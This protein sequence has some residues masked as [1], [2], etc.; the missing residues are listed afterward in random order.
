MANVARGISKSRSIRQIEKEINKLKRQKEKLLFSKK[1]DIINLTLEESLQRKRRESQSKLVEL[2]K[3]QKKYF[4]EQNRK[5]KKQLREDVDRIEWELIKVTLKEQGNN[6]AMEK[7]EKFKKSNAKPFFLW[8]L[9]FAEVFQR[10]NP[11]FDVVIA[12][13]PYVDSENMVKEMP[14]LRISYTELFISAKGNWDLFIIFIEQGLNLLRKKGDISYIVPNKLIGAKYSETLRKILVKKKVTEIRDYSGVNVFKEADVYPITFVISNKEP[15]GTVLMT[16]MNSINEKEN[17]NIIPGDLFYAD[18]DWGRYFVGDKRFLDILLKMNEKQELSKYFPNV[19]G[20]ATVNQAYKLKKILKDTNQ[21]SS[22]IKKFINTGTIDPYISL[23]GQKKTRYIKEGYMY[24]IVLESELE[25]FSD[26]RYNQACSE[27]IIIGGM[28]KNLECYYDSSEYLAGKSTTIILSGESNL[29]YLTALLNSKL[30]SFWY[31]IFFKSL[32]LSGGYLRISNNEIKRIPLAF[33][34]EVIQ[35]NIISIVNKILLLTE[36]E[37][38]LKNYE[39]N[40][41]VKQLKYQIDQL[42]YKIYKLT[43]EEIQIVEE[44][45]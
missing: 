40:H 39:K 30:I 13:P 34:S 41:K 38:F 5:T 16:L 32:S 17:Q 10:E 19:S 37:G 11:G 25:K 43:P 20:A 29:K 33:P 14:K 1:D 21:Y 4:N 9:Y 8:K 3:L 2:K 36:D 12:N 24:P 6:E 22:G 26:S 23:W 45:S 35:Q 28:T 7:L 31:K 15:D 44:F 42:V 27:K 18:I